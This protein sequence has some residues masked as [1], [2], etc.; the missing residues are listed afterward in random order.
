M[1]KVI[2]GVKVYSPENLGKKDVV[3]VDDKIEGIYDEVK[4]PKDFVKIEEIDGEGLLV[5]PG[6]IDC[7]VHITGGGGEGG[8]KTRTPELP[9]SELIKA[10]ITSV[11]GCIG[12]DGVCR[13]MR[14]LIAKAKALEEE[15]ITTY[16]YTGSYEV[17][18]NS[19]TDSIK[20]DLM[21]VDKIIGVGEIAISDHRS[22][23]PTFEQFVNLVA[24]T[25]VGGLLSGKAG[26]INVH[27]GGGARR[28]DY[29]FK[30]IEETEIPPTQLLP[31]HIN[32]TDKL[33]EMGIE[34]TKIGGFIDLTTSSD[35]DHLEEG[36]VRAGEGLKILLD[37]NVPIEHITFSSDGNG[38]MPLFDD[39]G[40]MVAL[41]ICSVDTLYREVKEAI[42]NH[43]IS[44]E[45][46]IKVITSNVATLLKLNN[47]GVIE[48]G[49]DADLVLVNEGDL[50]INKVIAKGK[51]VVDNGEPLIKGTFEK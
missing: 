6:F 25:R 43:D 18:V 47:K 32:R 51:L 35:P 24:Q 19:M 7:H 48:E 38:S 11:V 26:I 29:L 12:T 4:V 15:G 42:I 30:L 40:K 17:P 8:F 50:N 3:I 20:G 23:Q 9:L 36:E 41:G 44:I 2:K 45:D 28:L 13:N 5:F 16:C 27:L 14:S 37:K 31:T 39:E 22:S 21:L 10:G 49:K 33:L 1:I 46:A 34:Y